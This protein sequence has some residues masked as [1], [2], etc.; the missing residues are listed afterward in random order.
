MSNLQGGGPAFP[1]KDNENQYHGMNLRDYFAAQAL[2]GD[3][4]HESFN[5]DVTGK[6]IEKRAA[7]YYRIA[8]EMLKARK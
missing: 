3:L 7:L 5:T 1:N 2:A 4:A 8:D 6:F